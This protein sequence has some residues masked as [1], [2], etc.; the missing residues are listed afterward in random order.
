VEARQRHTCAG[1]TAAIIGRRRTPP[2]GPTPTPTP[3]PQ[4]HQDSHWG[5]WATAAGSSRPRRPGPAAEPACP[6]P[7]TVA[8]SERHWIGHWRPKDSSE[9][10]RKPRPPGRS[11]FRVGKGG[12]EASSLIPAPVAG[13]AA[14]R[15]PRPAP[16]GT[17]PTPR[18]SRREEMGVTV[19]T[20][21]LT[22]RQAGKFGAVLSNESS[23]FSDL[24]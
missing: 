13:A 16:A 20:R 9:S 23:K 24:K 10:R 18:C 4:H 19:A 11:L 5:S 17:I 6:A 3:P 8:L 14:H 21:T 12:S 1:P 2:P 15:S 22:G 7:A